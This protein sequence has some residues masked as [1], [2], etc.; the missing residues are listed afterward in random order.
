MKIVYRHSQ[1]YTKYLALEKVHCKSEQIPPLWL[2]DG[3]IEIVRQRLTGQL[4][5]IIFE[6]DEQAT[7]L[8]R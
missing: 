1:M 2:I 3:P 4:W 8:L 6:D 7:V 5:A